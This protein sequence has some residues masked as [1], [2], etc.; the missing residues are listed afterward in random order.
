M[1]DSFP[2]L[3]AQARE[4]AD[5]SPWWFVV[6]AAFLMAIM[7]AAIVVFVYGKLWFQA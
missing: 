1:L 5:A 2:L 4:A 6:I 7:V 3:L